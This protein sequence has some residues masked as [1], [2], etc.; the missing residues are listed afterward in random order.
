M[1][2]VVEV[3]SRLTG[4]R[5]VSVAFADFCPPLSSDRDGYVSLLQ[6]IIAHGQERGWKYLECRGGLELIGS[7]PSSVSFFGH[8]L[9]LRQ[10]EDALFK[11]FESSMRRS[12][13]KAETAGVKVEFSQEREAMQQ[14]YRLHCQTRQKHGVPPQ[15]VAFFE[16]IHRQILEKGQGTIALA[17]SNGLLAAASVFFQL[18]SKAIYKY[19]ASDMALQHLRANNVLMWEA[20][21]WHA[22]KGASELHF[23]R[24]SVANEG[25]RRFKLNFGTAEHELRYFRYDFKQGNFLSGQEAPPD[26]KN[27]VCSLLPVPVLRLA[28]RLLYRHMS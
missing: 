28:G 3:D 21:R 26:W 17:K 23:G 16:S 11:G 13:R 1:I 15:P 20:I 24:T 10:G 8:S 12:I 19:G 7:I 9:D 25:L 27:R 2:P 18:G 6:Q 22:R 5:G 14:F 4:R